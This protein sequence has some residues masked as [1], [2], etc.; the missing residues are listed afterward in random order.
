MHRT[1]PLV[2]AIGA[3]AALMYFL[4]PE[5][6][7]SRR[8]RVRD[9]A[10]HFGHTLS[11]ASGATWRD[12]R[13]RSTGVAA[14]LESM[15]GEH[16]TPSDDVL[17]ARVRSHL[18]RVVSH[19]RAVE[20]TAESGT[21]TLRGPVFTEEEQEL[22]ACVWRVPGV[23]DVVN[24]LEAHETDDIPAL[25]GGRVLPGAFQGQWSPATRLVGGVAGATLLLYGA[26]YPSVTGAIVGTTGGFLLAK[27]IS[28]LEMR[29][30]LFLGPSQH[31]AQPVESGA[32][33]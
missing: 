22:V 2:G 18:G 21:V 16:E 27:S 14:R 28:N 11:G 7:G 20:V 30:L 12:L 6:G 19:P 5:R 8:A 4:D 24:Q 33:I 9:K 25:Q 26:R 29:E 32:G 23:N 15:T 10:I 13:N 3:G 17:V 31:E 1:L